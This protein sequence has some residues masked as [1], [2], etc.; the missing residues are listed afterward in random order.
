MYDSLVEFGRFNP[1][2]GICAG[3]ILMATT[4]DD[5]R[6]N[7]LGLVNIDVE[8]NAYGR[9]MQS[10]TETVQ[11]NFTEGQ[12][13]NLSTTL[14]RAPKIKEIYGEMQ[15]IGRYENSPI[16]ILSGHH[17]CLS[18]HPELDRINIFHRVL[19]ESKSEIYYKKINRYYVA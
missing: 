10:R 12:E 7:P 16:A 19:F 5:K 11:F 13:F 14:I 3:L 17:L 2:M 8:R 4:V 1:V 6:I 18:F 15:V 9:Q